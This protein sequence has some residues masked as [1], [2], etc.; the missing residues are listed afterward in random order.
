MEVGEV[1]E[2]SGLK[3]LKR[4]S[5]I[6]QGRSEV[7]GCPNHPATPLG[8]CGSPDPAASF[9]LRRSR[10]IPTQLDFDWLSAPIMVLAFA[11]RH[12]NDLAAA[13][14][15]ALALSHLITA[16]WL[17]QSI[18][19]HWCANHGSTHVHGLASTSCSAFSDV[20][21]VVRIMVSHAVPWCGAWF[22]INMTPRVR[23]SSF[24]ISLLRYCIFF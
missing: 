19:A 5:V 13:V 20:V 23:P 12:V 18:T 3:R 17:P 16:P 15:T 22:S 9:L 11:H 1:H 2:A 4:P 24:R 6:G 10:A 21:K 8:N 14:N 7:C